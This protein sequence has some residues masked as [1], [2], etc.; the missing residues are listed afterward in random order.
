MCIYLYKKTHRITK[1]QYLGKTKNDPYTYRGSGKY[2]KLHLDKH[3]DDVETEILKECQSNEEIKQWGIYY[4]EL[5]NVVD[6]DEWANLKP[7][8]GD[9]GAMPLELVEQGAEKRRGQKRTPE[10]NEAK[11]K[12]QTGKKKSDTWL[13][14]RIGSKYTKH[15]K[16]DFVG[17]KHWNFDKTEYIFENVKTLQR[18]TAS[19]NL[20]GKIVPGASVGK[21]VSGIRKTTKGWRFVGPA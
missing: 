11:S 8:A 21:I 14:K 7:E 3:G 18:V 1:L 20:F 12:R 19:K 13:K 2:W 15:K 5:W 6:S 9:G 10:Q 17:E 4:S 16:T